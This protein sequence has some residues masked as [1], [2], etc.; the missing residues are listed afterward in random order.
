MIILWIFSH[1]MSDMVVFI[2]FIKGFETSIQEI[3]GIH[4]YSIAIL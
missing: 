4:D 1:Y 2:L 3:E